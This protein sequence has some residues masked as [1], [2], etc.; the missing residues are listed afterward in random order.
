M[1]SFLETCRLIWDK[2][3]SE[4]KENL[5][6]LMGRAAL[7]CLADLIAE[8]R[9]AFPSPVASWAFAH[10][11]KMAMMEE[12]QWDFNQHFFYL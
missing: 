2:P 6:Q 5:S 12:G 10:K 1:S 3:S 7:V 4:E 9:G 8:T 11:K